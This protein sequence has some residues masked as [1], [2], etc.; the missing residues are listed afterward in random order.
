MMA[1]SREGEKALKSELETHGEP[2][3]V[4]YLG[5]L[6]SHSLET[7]DDHD[8][9]DEFE[10]IRRH[11]VA[12]DPSLR[13]VVFSY[14][15]AAQLHSG[16]D[17]RVAWEHETYEG[18]SEPRYAAVETTDRPLADHVA[19][20][21]WLIRDILDRHPRACLDL[22]GFSLGGIIA[23]AWAADVP[24]H[25]ARLAAIH[26]ITLISSPVGGISSLGR[27]TPMPGIRHALRRYH[28]GFGRSLVFHDL[29]KSSPVIARLREVPTKVDVASIENSRDYVVNG[30][31]IT[32]QRLLPVWIRTIPLGRGASITSFLPAAECYVA[33]LGGWER[34]L[35]TTHRHVLRGDSPAIDLVRQH[36]VKLVTEDG[37]LW[38]AR[39]ARTASTPTTIRQLPQT[40]RALNEG[41][42][43]VAASPRHYADSIPART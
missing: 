12:A 38:T 3:F 43:S 16:S 23:L 30:R 35:R 19:A 41:L 25:D 40:G 8:L 22:I 17:P 36:L 31:R 42:L 20:V 11:L 27:L 6:Q 24:A 1:S 39:H 4:I 13:F 9:R 29:R 10:P 5:G 37:P 7:P 2:R 14:G 32:G 28:I 34:H 21:D 15:A 33:D 26:R 18:G